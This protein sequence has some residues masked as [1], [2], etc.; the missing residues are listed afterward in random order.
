M[1]TPKPISEERLALLRTLHLSTLLPYSA[2]WSQPTRHQ[3]GSWIARLAPVFTELLDE[4]DALDEALD[5]SE[6]EAEQLRTAARLTPAVPAA[7][8]VPATTVVPVGSA[9]L[10]RTKSGRW[11]VRWREDGRQRSSSWPTRVRAERARYELLSPERPPVVEAPAV[12]VL[13][14]DAPAIA[15]PTTLDMAAALHVLLA[16]HPHLVDLPLRWGFSTKFGVTA[17]PPG[18]SFDA[19][20]YAERLAT[21]LG[22]EVEIDRPF[23]HEGVHLQPHRVSGMVAGVQ[24]HLA[25]Y[26][27]VTEQ[28][29][30]GAE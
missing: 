3:A 1:S 22:V 18:R 2:A 30:G 9:S 16:A 29:A 8:A 19:P 7:L 23:S 14:L 5:A 20:V 17:D 28:P 11:Q 6:T 26:V 24:I 21:A 25:A 4:I 10:R 15:E 13:A 12:G 27:P